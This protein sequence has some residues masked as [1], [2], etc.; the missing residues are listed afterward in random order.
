MDSLNILKMNINQHNKLIVP[1]DNIYINNPSK[2]E[3][4]FEKFLKNKHIYE[5]NQFTRYVST[6][7][8][9]DTADPLGIYEEIKK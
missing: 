1:S 8:N 9:Y 6:I 3:S 7:N 5:D 4:S 2:Y